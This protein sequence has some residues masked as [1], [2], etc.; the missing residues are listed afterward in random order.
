M[1]RMAGSEFEIRTLAD[2]VDG[3]EGLAQVVGQRV[4]GGDDL[5]S[6]LRTDAPDPF[7]A[8]RRPSGPAAKPRAAWTPRGA[9]AILNQTFH[10]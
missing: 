5:P 1:T 6:G 10:P 2:A 8:R 4:G 3:V 9:P 7:V